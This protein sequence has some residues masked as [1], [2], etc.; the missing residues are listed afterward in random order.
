MN[1]ARQPVA[2]WLADG[3]PA[4][5]DA[6]R[7]ADGSLDVWFFTDAW[8]QPA[9]LR[10]PARGGQ[11]PSAHLAEVVRQERRPAYDRGE[12]F[13]PSGPM[14]G[15][16]DALLSWMAHDGQ[17][18]IRF[19]K[20][21]KALAWLAADRLAMDDL[22]LEA[23][24]FRLMV[25]DSPTSQSY[26][27]SLGWFARLI[28]ERPDQGLPIDRAH[29]W[30]V[31]AI[32]AAYGLEGDAWRASFKP[33]LERYTDL[34]LAAVMPSGLC[35]YSDN[36]EILGGR[37]VAVQTFEVAFVTLMQ[38]ALVE[39]V[40]RGVDEERASALREVA[41]RATDYLYFGAPF[42]R[43]PNRRNPGTK[44]SGPTTQFA[45]APLGPGGGP[46][47]EPPFSAEARWGEA[48]LPE[49]GRIPDLV[50]TTYAYDVLAYADDWA[51]QLGLADAERYF[52]RTLALDLGS[53]SH[54]ARV[55]AMRREDAQLD[56]TASGNRAAYLA[57]VQHLKAR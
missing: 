50:E 40:F 1:V 32:V 6:W 5:A 49:D 45:I 21:A 37:Y 16:D 36:R 53:P 20:N 47:S 48:Y 8:N 14:P 35:M 9:E 46:S 27:R 34:M 13:A 41:L 11:A 7:A 51:R 25:H 57:R 33:W 56:F 52:A 23:E 12:P 55:Q 4:G 30:G 43:G 42:Q 24:R 26:D 29:A 19:T 28:A 44:I 22:L 39:G 2:M 15:G 10:L 18:L 38:R 31:D 54:T 17:H 3:R